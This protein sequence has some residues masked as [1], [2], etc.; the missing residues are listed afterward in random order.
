MCS[1]FPFNKSGRLQSTARYL[2]GSA[3]KR[4]DVLKFQKLISLK[5]QVCFPEFLIQQKKTPRKIFPECSEIVGILSGP[6]LY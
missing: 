3:Q 4:K 5:L 1:H 2:P 6:G